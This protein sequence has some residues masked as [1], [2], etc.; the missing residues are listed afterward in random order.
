MSSWSERILRWY[1]KAV[2]NAPAPAAD[3]EAAE[4]ELGTPLP[5]ELKA[6]LRESNGALEHPGGFS[7]YW[8]IA[9]IRDT[10]LEFRTKEDFKDIFMPFDCLLFFADAGNG[11]PFAY[12]VLAGAV[13]RDDIFVWNHEDDSRTWCAPSLETFLQWWAEG[14]I[15]V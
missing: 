14:K 9:E 4:R 3:I 7:I 10:N 5:E 12:S 2:F 6:L 15:A 8:P 11:D 13:R 1:P